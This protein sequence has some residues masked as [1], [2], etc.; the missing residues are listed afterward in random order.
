[1]CLDKQKSNVPVA[2]W[3]T[4]RKTEAIVFDYGT[5]SR[6][7][8]GFAFG[9]HA[10]FQVML[11]LGPQTETKNLT[12]TGFESTN[13]KRQATLPPSPKL[14]KNREKFLQT[15]AGKYLSNWAQKM[16][17]PPKVVKTSPRPGEV[18]NLE[19]S[20]VE[21]VKNQR[22]E[23][24]I[25]QPKPGNIPQKVLDDLKRLYGVKKEEAKRLGEQKRTQE[26]IKKITEDLSNVDL[27]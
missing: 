20:V 26:E 11:E 18:P 16:K 24:E 17:Q 14:N 2:Q 12:G 9:N 7:G 19:D 6:V 23:Y 10:D 5:D 15:D 1:M 21:L 13:S 25:H 3:L 8:F 22:G 4:T 27:D